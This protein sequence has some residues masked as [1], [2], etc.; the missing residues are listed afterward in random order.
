MHVQANVQANE[1][2][3]SISA[4]HNYDLIANGQCWCYAYVR[5]LLM[6]SRFINC[7]SSSTN[8][9]IELIST[10]HSQPLD[11]VSNGQYVLYVGL[12]CNQQS[13]QIWLALCMHSSTIT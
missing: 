4:G 8:E 12:A 7:T 3:E 11:L 13:V 9:L 6:Q 5:C 1:L 10:G 2:I